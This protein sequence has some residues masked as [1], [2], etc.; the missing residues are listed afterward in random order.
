MQKNLLQNLREMNM[1]PPGPGSGGAAASP[2][3]GSSGAPLLD[4]LCGR[5]YW[6]SEMIV[7]LILYSE[8]RVVDLFYLSFLICSLCWP[9]EGNI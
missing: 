9:I 6:L 7:C 2:D 5:V 8:M 1:A 3:R 4:V